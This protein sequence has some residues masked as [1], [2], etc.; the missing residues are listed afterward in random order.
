M[1]EVTITDNRGLLL[2]IGK[3]HLNYPEAYDQMIEGI[4]II[5]FEWE[6]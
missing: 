1:D 4:A 5:N 3:I 6:C 2:S